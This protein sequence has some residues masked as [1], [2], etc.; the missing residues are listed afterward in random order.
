VPTPTRRW[1]R[2]AEARSILAPVRENDAA[3]E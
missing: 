1:S 3:A 2:S